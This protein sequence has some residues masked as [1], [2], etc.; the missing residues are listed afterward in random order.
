VA[1]LES[2]MTQTIELAIWGNQ[3]LKVRAMRPQFIDVKT[4]VVLFS[5][6]ASSLTGHNMPIGISKNTMPVKVSISFFEKPTIILDLFS[7]D[8]Q[9]V[10]DGYHKIFKNVFGDRP[11][12]MGP[13]QMEKT[14]KKK[15]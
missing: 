8:T 4:C 11:I 6:V 1:G 7:H 13:L 2:I 3:N 14:K 12:K 5:V 10:H 9:G 15:L